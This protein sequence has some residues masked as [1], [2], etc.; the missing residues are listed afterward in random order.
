MIEAARLRE[1]PFCGAND[2]DL[3]RGQIVG[4]VDNGMRFVRCLSCG[5]STAYRQM[6]DAVS[7]WNERA[8]EGSPSMPRGK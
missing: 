4:P 2:V 5:A 6:A 3:W 7:S 1:C 8:H